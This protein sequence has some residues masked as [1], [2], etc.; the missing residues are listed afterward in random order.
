MIQRRR[1]KSHETHHL[2]PVPASQAAAPLRGRGTC[3]LS[4]GLVGAARHCLRG[5]LPQS[6]SSRRSFPAALLAAALAV[7][8][9]AFSLRV[10]AAFLPAV[11]RPRV[12]VAFRPAARR[13][14]VVAA[15]FAPVL[16]FLDVR[17]ELVA[18]LPPKAEV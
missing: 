6:G 8:A 5:F 3:E 2:H 12:L 4:G 7:L 16:R 10:Y 1:R 13:L 11:L 15:F 9:A 14:R 18:M 17:L